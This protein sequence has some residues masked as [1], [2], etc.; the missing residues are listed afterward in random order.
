M[1]IEVC[2]LVHYPSPST[3]ASLMIAFK[4]RAILVIGANQLA[5]SRAFMALE[6]GAKVYV[7]TEDLESACDEIRWRVDRG[8]ITWAPFPAEKELPDALGVGVEKLA[9]CLPDVNLV[10]VT[11]TLISSDGAM[12]SRKT[13]ET[14]ASVFRKRGIPVNV[15]DNPDL[16]DYTFPSTHRFTAMSG[17]SQSPTSLQIGVTTNGK[18]CRL[19]GRIKREI[20]AALPKQVGV[21][22]ENIG[23]MRV[24]AN[25]I[26]GS[27]DLSRTMDSTEE[28]IGGMGAPVNAPVPQDR[29]SI[30]EEPI[31]SQKR[32]M[33]WIAQMSEYWP[34]E[35]LAALT[36]NEMEHTLT[37]YREGGNE[38]ES[39]SEGVLP[40]RKTT[41]SHDGAKEKSVLIAATIASVDG[42]SREPRPFEVNEQSDA[43]SRHALSIEQPLALSRPQGRILLVGSG[44]GHPGLLAVAARR[45]LTELGTVILSDKLVPSGVLALIPKDKTLYIA[46]KF[47]GNAEG[48]Q[49]ELMEMA[50]AAANKGEIV[51]R[52]KQ[53]DPFLYGRGGEEVLYFRSQGFEPLVIPGISS[54]LAAPLTSGIAVTQRGVAESLLICTGVGRQGRDVELPGYQR[55]QSLS[56]L[57][58]VAR[59]A[60]LVEAL[61]DIP[62][63]DKGGQRKGDPYPL[64]LPVAIIERSSCPDQRVVFSTLSNVVSAMENCGEQRP[65]AMIFVGWAAMALSG[66][67]DL[68]VLDDAAKFSGK[69]LIARDVDRVSRWL[70]PHGVIVR[71]GLQ[72]TWD[73]IA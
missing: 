68:A 36:R 14:I 55:Q 16:C 57:M 64:H 12:L 61:T 39:F 67:G 27:V 28:A 21:A 25:S 51:V 72:D 41:A 66:S 20:I 26:H 6:A 18:A 60:Q 24:D 23:K 33:R 3:G 43:D 11:D 37:R 9:A 69:D 15:T 65:P 40:Q 19:A 56:I 62:D 13:V 73:L 48:A 34:L 7:S 50:V 58:G 53:G 46:K 63:G 32:R 59:L 54:A 1:T 8:Q 2:S 49:N 47:P 38:E 5:A 30:A 71:E 4:P 10:C 44:P 42:T 35:R 22:V 29:R 31:T 70:G 52:L 17:G 45:A